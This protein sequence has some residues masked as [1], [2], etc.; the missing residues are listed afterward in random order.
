[1]NHATAAPGT[2]GIDTQSAHH[3]REFDPDHDCE[4]CSPEPVTMPPPQGRPAPDQ[5]GEH[6]HPPAE[7]A[8]TQIWS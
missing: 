5:P 3:G 6:P 8:I 1:M 7:S 2:D 4:F